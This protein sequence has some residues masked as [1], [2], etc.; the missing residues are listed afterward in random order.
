MLFRTMQQAKHF[1]RAVLGFTL[2][3]LGI[4]AIPTPVPGL[5]LVGLG[6]GILAADFDWAQRLL[7]R[8]KELGLRAR[9]L[10]AARRVAPDA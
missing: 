2:L 4:V 9:A 8:I 3:V 1:A 6:L 5:L 7:G 10:R